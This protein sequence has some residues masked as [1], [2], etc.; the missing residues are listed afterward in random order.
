MRVRPTRAG[1]FA[2]GNGERGHE[3]EQKHVE[4]GGCAYRTFGFGRAAND[5]DHRAP[6]ENAFLLAERHGVFQNLPRN[7]L[8]QAP[9]PSAQPP[10]RSGSKDVSKGNARHAQGTDGLRPAPCARLH[11]RARLAPGARHAVRVRGRVRA[12]HLAAEDD[13]LE[14]CGDG[15]VLGDHG[16]E[17]L[18]RCGRPHPVGVRRAV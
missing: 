12:A 9:V 11:V 13:A 15:G 14:P 18:H 4:L 16:L 7:G 2:R 10:A 8:T 1:A 3:V 17:L 5:V 6:I